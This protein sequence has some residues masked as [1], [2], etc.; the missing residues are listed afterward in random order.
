M[1]STSAR[2][3][4]LEHNNNLRKQATNMHMGKRYG[5]CGRHRDVDAVVTAGSY[6]KAVVTAATHLQ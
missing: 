3:R 6:R 2:A 4:K 5:T 1:P